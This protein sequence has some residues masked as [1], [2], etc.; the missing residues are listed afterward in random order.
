VEAL[1]DW[2]VLGGLVIQ[3]TYR[4]GHTDINELNGVEGLGT[5]EDQC[6]CMAINLKLTFDG[7]LFC[8]REWPKC[9][10]WP[11]CMAR[12]PKQ[13]FL[14][15][16][17]VLHLPQRGRCSKFENSATSSPMPRESIWALISTHASVLVDSVGPPSAEVCRAAAS[18][19]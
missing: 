5:F 6:F 14:H 11:L 15:P 4:R 13:A 10:L 17:E 18:F 16:I 12:N 9:Q 19:P 2:P 7:R 3:S 8:K 1:S